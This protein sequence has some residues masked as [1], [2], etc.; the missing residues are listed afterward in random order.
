MKS[1]SSTS[2]ELPRRYTDL[3]SWYPLITDADEYEEEAE[4][5]ADVFRREIDGDASTLLEL[6]AG[7]GANAFHYKR[8]FETTLTDA[9]SEMLELSKR[10]NPDC[11]HVVGDMRTLRLSRVFDAVFVHDAV[12]YITNADD[13][14]QVAETALV[15]LRR[16]GAAIF[17]PDE[18]VEAFH[19]HAEYGGRD[20]DDRALRFLNWTFDPDPTDGIYVNEWVYVLHEREKPSVIVHESHECGVFARRDW[21]DILR[22]AGFTP[23]L[24]RFEHSEVPDPIDV[25][26]ARKP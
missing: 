5:Y 21:V 26:V 7:S 11:E 23:E 25:F 19:D 15:H 3:A 20:G 18:T 8:H 1:P 4:F 9:S 2:G 17:V 24:V 14:R 22:D 12:S 13:L 6:G 16:G 10:I